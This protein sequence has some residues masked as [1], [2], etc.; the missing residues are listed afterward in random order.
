MIVCWTRLAPVTSAELIDAA[1]GINYFLLPSIEWV[2]SRT[3]VDVQIIVSQGRFGFERVAAAAGNSN[4]R[5]IWV[6]FGLHGVVLTCWSRFV[7]ERAI[8]GALA[9]KFKD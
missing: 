3:D 7:T 6:D 1:G 5:V 2:A 8:L 9:R 4:R